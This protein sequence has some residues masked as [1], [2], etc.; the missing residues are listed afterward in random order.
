MSDARHL[1]LHALGVLKAASAGDVAR[2]S[3]LD[4]TRVETELAAA[5]ASGRVVEAGGRWT[6]TPLARLALHAD[7]SRVHAGLRDDLAFLSANDRFEA[8]NRDLKALITDWQTITVAGTRIANDHGDPDHDAR[9]IDRLAALHERADAVLAVLVASAPQLDFY[10]RHL[11][12]A[13]ER[14]EDGDIA[15]VSDAAIE[16]YHTLWFELHEEL[17][18]MRGGTRTE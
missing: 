5:G 18:R 4:P 14:A 10:R 12:A 13:L 7:Y 8:I 16:S 9:I 6:L 15:W 11:L 17:I 2:R 3:G 1:V